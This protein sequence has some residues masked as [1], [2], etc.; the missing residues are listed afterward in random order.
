MVYLCDIS[1]SWARSV[2]LALFSTVSGITAKAKPRKL[3]IIFICRLLAQGAKYQKGN[4]MD[5]KVIIVTG[6]NGGIGMATALNL[7]QRGARIYLACRNKEKGEQTMQEIIEQTG[8]PN[9]VCRCL[10]LAS[11]ASIRKFVDE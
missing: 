7:A 8:N 9:V 6:A 4:R 3:K 2:W 11:F 1:S 5:G 10:D